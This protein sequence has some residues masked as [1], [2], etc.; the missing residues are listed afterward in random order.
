MFGWAADVMEEAN[1]MLSRTSDELASKSREIENMEIA[2]G[3]RL[4]EYESKLSNMEVHKDASPA[5]AEIDP[6][7]GCYRVKFQCQTTRF[8][9]IIR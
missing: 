5:V 6:F 3:Q 7:L 1:A 2:L 8:R 4:E 9:S